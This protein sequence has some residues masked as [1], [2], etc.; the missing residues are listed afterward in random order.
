M[1]RRVRRVGDPHGRLAVLTGREREIVG[2]VATGLG[3][4]DIPGR[5]VRTG[6]R[7]G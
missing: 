3:N 2:L 6:H 4:D 1:S 7:G 5:L